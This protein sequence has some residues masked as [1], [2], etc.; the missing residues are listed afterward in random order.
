MKQN[1]RLEQVRQ[2]SPLLKLKCSAVTWVKQAGCTIKGKK[3]GRLRDFVTQ[4][5]ICLETEIK[6]DGSRKTV[7]RHKLKVCAE[8]IIFDSLERL[9][10]HCPNSSTKNHLYASHGD[11]GWV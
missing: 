1:P 11:D 6:R 8:S 10:F 9:V 4:K 2:I 3:N 7:S 5:K